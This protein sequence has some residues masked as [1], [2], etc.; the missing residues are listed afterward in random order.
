MNVRNRSAK[1]AGIFQGYN[2]LWEENR[3]PSLETAPI[4]TS[5][6]VQTP[7]SLLYTLPNQDGFDI[8][9]QA[10]EPLKQSEAAG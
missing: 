7:Q 2:V 10:W 1:F 6:T 9:F 3:V 5:P 8:S 4:K